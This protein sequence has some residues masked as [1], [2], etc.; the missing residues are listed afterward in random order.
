M[1]NNNSNLGNAAFS[2]FPGGHDIGKTLF[3]HI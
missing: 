3:V 2:G 1:A